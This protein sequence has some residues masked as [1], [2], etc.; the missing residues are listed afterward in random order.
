LPCESD[1]RI[2]PIAAKVICTP[3]HTQDSLSLVFPDRLFTGD[4]LFL[5]DA[6]GGRD[7]LPGGDAGDHW[8][9]LQR[10]LALP[11]HLVVYPAHEYRGRQPSVLRR[12]RQTNPHLAVPT[13][14][15]FVQYVEDL[16]LGPADW[17]RDVLKANYAC[18]QD[19]RAAWIPADL[20]ACE[21]Q[22]TL[23]HGVN[24][25]EVSTTTAAE[26]RERMA[27]GQ[28]PILVDV[29]EVDELTAE[30]GH[31]PAIRH[32]PIGALPQRLGEL[33]TDRDKEIVTVCRSGSRAHTAAQI[34]IQAGFPK[35]RV[36]AGG[37][38]AWRDAG[39]PVEGR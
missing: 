24:D 10:I 39:Y 8:E 26:L 17:M 30:L 19:P 4:V 3:G 9:S 14:E 7:D 5:D 16:R 20:P 12:Q 22:G 37:M 2:G 34:L 6:G 29:R 31:L 15:A 27:A 11:D 33:D 21:I 36:L 1:W 28:A 13:K 35:A 25:V 32:I 38:I 18:A 23:Q